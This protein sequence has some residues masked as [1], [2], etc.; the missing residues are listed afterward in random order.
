MCE[1]NLFNDISSNEPKQSKPATIKQRS[2]LG[3]RFPASNTQ[4]TTRATT[5]GDSAYDQNHGRRKT[6]HKQVPS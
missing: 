3:R 5:K 4:A 2:F 6:R 1:C